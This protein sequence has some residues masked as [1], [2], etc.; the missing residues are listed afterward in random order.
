MC[1]S[2]LEVRNFGK[3]GYSRLNWFQENQARGRPNDWKCRAGARY[4]YICEDGLVHYCSQQRGNPG[5]PLEDFT[6]A[7]MRREYLTQKTCA[8]RCT[9]GCVQKVSI[10][11]HFRDAQV[12]TTDPT[13][14]G[15]SHTH[16][17]QN[18]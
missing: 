14:S 13:S 11:D 9:V 2:D 3:R 12:S 17:H 10:L 4:I 16:A 5:T 1:S 6:F 15:S 18:V 7:D 8:P